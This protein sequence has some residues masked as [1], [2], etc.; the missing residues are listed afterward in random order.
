MTFEQ[1][2]EGSEGVGHMDILGE[3]ILRRENSKCK[4]PE[5]EACRCARE[6]QNVLN[7]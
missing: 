6:Q 2:L 3:N 5:A 4:G 7:G 1:K